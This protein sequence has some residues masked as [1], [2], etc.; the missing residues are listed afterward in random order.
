MDFSIPPPPLYPTVANPNLYANP[1]S[2]LLTVVP[3]VA[4]GNS[5]NP[6]LVT[7]QPQQDPT[8]YIPYNSIQ[9]HSIGNIGGL[10]TLQQTAQF[11]RR[12]YRGGQR[13][14]PYVTGNR[15][16]PALCSLLVCNFVL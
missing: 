5:Y 7:V 16:D 13:F 15:I 8:A 11:A 1:S 9:A 12:G 2:T 10:G 14:K 3:T 4:S 6:N